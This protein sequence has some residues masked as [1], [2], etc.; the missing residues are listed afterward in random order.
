MYF[1]PSPCNGTCA[2]E[3][4]PHIEDST[5]KQ[6]CT[7]PKKC[8]DSPFGVEFE[9]GLNLK[10]GLESKI[11][12]II[13]I[14][15]LAVEVHN[16]CSKSNLLIYKSRIVGRPKPYSLERQGRKGRRTERGE[17]KFARRGKPSIH[18][19][20]TSILQDHFWADPEV[21]PRHRR[22]RQ[23]LFG[24]VSS[25]RQHRQQPTPRSWF[26]SGRKK[27]QLEK[28]D[29]RRTKEDR[30]DVGFWLG[31]G[32]D[33][34]LGLVVLGRRGLGRAEGGTEEGYQE[35]MALFRPILCHVDGWEK[36]QFPFID[37]REQIV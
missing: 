22:P 27:N 5:K 9:L 25:T 10:T 2:I 7:T 19:P 24:Q 16:N 4:A 8:F 1:N 17:E 15:T 33:G 3:C 30:S 31:R 34:R 14:L 32:G 13:E 18:N 11:K 28:I 21:P 12:V 36:S 6:N 20:S 26:G 23:D 29:R 35:G 37:E